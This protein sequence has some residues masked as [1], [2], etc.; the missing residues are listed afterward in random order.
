MESAN[1]VLTRRALDIL[2]SIATGTYVPPEERQKSAE[3]VAEEETVSSPEI[4]ENQA[5]VDE[6]ENKVD[7]IVGDTSTDISAASKSE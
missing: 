6:T 5:D 1:R 2:K 7:E 4:S 3:P